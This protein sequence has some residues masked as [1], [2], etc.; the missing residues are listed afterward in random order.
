LRDLNNQVIAAEQ[1][2]KS[3]EIARTEA[4]LRLAAA[5]AAETDEH[6]RSQARMA[7]GLVAGFVSRGNALDEK[8]SAFVTEFQ[9]L[10]R[11]FLELQKVNYP[12]ATCS[13]G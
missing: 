3:L 13:Q 8:L 10:N 7:L 5:Q 11:D 1:D 6:E 9:E 2:C 4:E 12:P